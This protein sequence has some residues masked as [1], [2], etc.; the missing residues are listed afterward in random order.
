MYTDHTQHDVKGFLV[1]LARGQL[2]RFEE[3]SD[4]RTL[5]IGL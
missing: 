4:E 3:V 1:A 2:S 5:R